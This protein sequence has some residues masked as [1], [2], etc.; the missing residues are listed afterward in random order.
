MVLGPIVGGALAQSSATW[1][2]GF[3][4]NL[5][6]GGLFS[7]IWIFIL[8]GFDPR[9]S[10][11]FLSRIGDFDYIGAFL[12]IAVIVCLLAGINFGGVVYDWNS[13]QIIALFVLSGTICI[14]FALQ[15][16]F[17][18]GTKDEHRMFPVS[19]LKNKE[20]VLLFVLM[21]TGNAGGF[22]PVYYIPP[23]FQFARGED[24]LSSA[25]RLIPLIIFISGMVLVNGVIMGKWGYYQPWYT[26][27]SMIALVG[28]VLFCKSLPLQLSY[29]V[30]MLIT[31]AT[32]TTETSTAR[33]YG[34]QV[35]LGLGAGAYAQAGYAVIQVIVEPAMMAYGIGFMMLGESFE[36]P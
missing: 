18:V 1:R 33:I 14:A 32:I 20:A 36:L 31:S 35:L 2:W 9:G 26:G 19:F 21:T 4:L 24:P 12:S 25:V 30:R 27:G 10:Q 22:I 5:C 15:Q 13:G 8:P 3:Y 23:Y 6:I 11:S 29:F 16:I 17:A 7:P 28:A 34:Y